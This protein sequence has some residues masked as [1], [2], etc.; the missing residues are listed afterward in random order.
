M[1][2]RSLC[3]MLVAV[4]LLLILPAQPAE[5]LPIMDNHK[6]ELAENV[7]RQI[8]AGMPSWV[9]TD[10]EKVV[11][12]HNYLVATVTYEHNSNDYNYG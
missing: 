1:M 9:D 5:A 3:L 7:A 8:V 6:Q 12:L 11:Y 4:M 2:R 10:E